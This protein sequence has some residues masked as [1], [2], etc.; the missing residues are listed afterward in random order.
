M[1]SSP[2]CLP[3]LTGPPKV[4]FGE[5]PAKHR[6]APTLP[7]SPWHTRVNTTLVRTQEF[8]FNFAAWLFIPVHKPNP[9]SSAPR[10]FWNRHSEGHACRNHI[11]QTDRAGLKPSNSTGRCL[12]ERQDTSRDP[13]C[14]RHNGSTEPR[15]P[16]ASAI[17]HHLAAQLPAAQSHPQGTFGTSFSQRF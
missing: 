9:G 15:L 16:A 6:L 5:Q 11:S 8:R 10:G 13:F 12:S 2:N 17:R 1:S 3:L 4:S 7:E 14:K